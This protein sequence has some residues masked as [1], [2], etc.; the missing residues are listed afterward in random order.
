MGGAE[1]AAVGGSSWT[2]LPK[3]M[4]LLA[5]G[6]VSG[7]VQICTLNLFPIATVNG[8]ASAKPAAVS[9]STKAAVL[10]VCER[11]LRTPEVLILALSQLRVAQL[12]GSVIHRSGKVKR[13]CI[14]EMRTK[15]AAK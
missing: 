11:S 10:S 8:T 6:D 9:A 13:K 14:S 12:D 7:R 2:P 3:L 15:M 5:V 4:T 1:A